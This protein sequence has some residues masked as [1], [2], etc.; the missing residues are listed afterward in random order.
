MPDR[1]LHSLYCTIVLPYINYGI[2]LWGSGW[3][4]DVDKIHKLQKWAVRTISN[5]HYWSHSE[6]LFLKYDILNVYDAYKLE[7][8][9]FMYKY[10]IGLL[11]KIFDGLFTKK[12]W[13][14]WLP[15]KKE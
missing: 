13:Y 4:T 11:S 8:G 9:V 3:R 10:F 12:V 6:P 7:V 5:T 2:L 1:I 15:Y 14:S